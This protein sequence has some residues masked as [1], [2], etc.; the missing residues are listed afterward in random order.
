MPTKPGQYWVAQYVY[1]P[2]HISE[3][4]LQ[5]ATSSLMGP[6]FP[7]PIPLRD[8]PTL[9]QSFAVNVVYTS[10]NARNALLDRLV[11]PCPGYSWKRRWR[12][13]VDALSLE[14]LVDGHGRPEVIRDE[15]DD[16]ITG[17]AR[18]LRASPAMLAIG[19]AAL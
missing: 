19:L 13:L 6:L 8:H 14:Y 7:S 3:D 15:Y 12:C 5:L 9:T 11:G 4:T 1:V 18:N 17:W 16:L 2:N 10:R